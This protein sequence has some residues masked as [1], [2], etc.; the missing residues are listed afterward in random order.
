R[1]WALS[2]APGF[3]GERG[4]CV[5]MPRN[6]PQA[7]PKPLLPASLAP[8]LSLLQMMMR[9]C[10][11]RARAGNELEFELCLLPHDGVQKEL[12]FCLELVFH[13]LGSSRD[14]LCPVSPK[15]R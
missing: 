10:N 1:I 15:R 6:R 8:G 13:N 11:I 12:R 4:R 14:N 9:S 3:D 2:P 7:S 5:R